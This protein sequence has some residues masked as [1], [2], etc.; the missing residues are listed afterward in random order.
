[1]EEEAKKNIHVGK[2][3]RHLEAFRLRVSKTCLLSHLLASLCQ[4]PD[5]R[6]L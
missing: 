3:E 4:A 1:M 2:E 5:N 6:P